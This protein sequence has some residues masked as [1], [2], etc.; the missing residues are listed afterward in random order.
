[1]IVIEK[2]IL[3]KVEA[4]QT[5]KGT[6]YLKLVLNLGKFPNSKYDNKI[7]VEVFNEHLMNQV[8]NFNLFSVVVVTGRLNISAY[9]S[10]AT[11]NPTYKLRINASSVE[12]IN[13]MDKPQTPNP[14]STVTDEELA[15]EFM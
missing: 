15:A 8:K 13:P 9:I 4:L 3:E 5:A 7:D 6:Q 1:M 10:Q 12:L 14:Y 2:G 11:N